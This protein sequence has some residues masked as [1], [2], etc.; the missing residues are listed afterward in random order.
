MYVDLLVK[1]PLKDVEFWVCTSRGVYAEA[2]RR[3]LIA[4][5]ERRGIKVLR[6]MCIVVTKIRE[7]GYDVVWTNSSK[8]AHYL[9]LLHKVEVR[10]SSIED[11]LASLDEK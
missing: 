11:I 10:L 1:R 4:S 9:R 6:D 8:A 5:L 3:G 7:M 2:E